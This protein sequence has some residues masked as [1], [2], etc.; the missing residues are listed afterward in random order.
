MANIFNWIERVM[1]AL[2]YFT[3]GKSMW[4]VTNWEGLQTILS[5][6]MSLWGRDLAVMTLKCVMIMSC[7][8][9][10]RKKYICTVVQYRKKW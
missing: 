6:W 8:D 4:K 5:W 1:Y 3:A 2:F 10:N 7:P 9:I